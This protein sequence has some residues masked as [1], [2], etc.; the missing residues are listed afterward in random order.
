ML[1]AF[2]NQITLTPFDLS[3]W[4]QVSLVHQLL[5]PLRQWRQG[6]WL[7]P[8]GDWIGLGLLMAL[9]GLA[10][11]VSTALIGILMMA[12][13]ALWVLLTLTDE[14]G[15][16]L[17]PI[18]L[19]VILFW[20]VMA[21]ATAISPVKAAALQGLVKLTL[22]LLVFLLMARV[23]RRSQARNWLVLALLLTSL[24]VAGYG[25]RQYFFGAAALATWVDPLSASATATRVYSY[26]G[27]PNL[28][29]GYLIPAV[30]L[31]AMAVFAWPRWLPKL[32]ALLLVGVNTICLVL[33]LSRGAWIGFLVGGFIL[34]ALVVHFWSIRF[35]P[36]WR[37]WA[38]PLLL[39]SAA[40][41]TVLGVLAVD[42]LRARVLSMFAG[43]Q[44]SSNN[45][46]INV[47]AAVIEMIKD[48]PI[49]GIGPG[50]DAFNAVYPLY[51]RPRYTALSAYSIFLETA[52]EAGLVG[53]AVLIW[54]L[55][56]TFSQGW[57][58]LQRLRLTQDNQAYWLMGAIASQAGMLCHGLVDTIWYRPQVSTLWWLMMAIVASYYVT[59][60]AP[61]D[62]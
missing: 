44:D 17:T 14:A 29:G 36:F 13:G 39:G 42:P 31:S 23:L 9:F 11:Y 58:Q 3:S 21:L 48:R 6:S 61:A 15:E 16:G 25:L 59:A 52:V 27:N 10:P 30:G 26:L 34:L 19:M 51:Q 40:A 54:L 55:V 7:L 37:R 56:V 22:N 47:W 32:L 12:A 60:A 5:A 18:H 1:N 41:V 46:R 2:W 43:R 8:W 62:E 20:G 53:L 38:M 28:L 33:T 57:V 35:T 49:L 50:N 45:F 4:R 24:P